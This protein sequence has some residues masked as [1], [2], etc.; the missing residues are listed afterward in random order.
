[1]RMPHQRAKAHPHAVFFQWPLRSSGDGAQRT[2]E[3]GSN[4]SCAAC[5]TTAEQRGWPSYSVSQSS[6]ITSRAKRRTCA[7]RERA[8]AMTTASSPCASTLM[9]ST[10]CAAQPRTDSSETVGTRR[11]SVTFQAWGSTVRK[12]CRLCAGV[13]LWTRESPSLIG[14]LLHPPGHRSVWCYTFLHHLSRLEAPLIG[15]SDEQPAF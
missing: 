11:V 15:S 2:G 12:E 9:K 6:L 7:S 4:P 1:M 3:A 13:L 14:T 8:D 10:G 5:A